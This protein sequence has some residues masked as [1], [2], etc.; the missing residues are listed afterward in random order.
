MLHSNQI[1]RLQSKGFTL[2]ELLV[3]I[4]IIGILVALLLPAINSARQAAYRNSCRN[5]LKQMSLGANSYADANTGKVPYSYRPPGATVRIANL[6]LL[7]PFIEENNSFKK[8]DL[9]QNWSAAVNLPVT[10][11]VIAT[12]VCP[13]QGEEI[14]RED[15]DPQG[16]LKGTKVACGDY[17]PLVAVE[18]RLFDAGEVDQWG[19]G[20]MCKVVTS[21]DKPPKLKEITDGVSKTIFYSESHGRPFVYQGNTKLTGSF[22]T[23]HVNGGGWSRPA[24]DFSLD[25]STF[26]GKSFPGKC[27]INCT[28]G[29]DVGS[30]FP[31]PVYNTDGSGETYAFHPGGAHV[32]MADGSVHFINDTISIREF[33]RLVT[34]SGGEVSPSVE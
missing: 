9:T 6:T 20:A 27:A 8:L 33:A 26:D 17:S 31:H 23:N 13:S 18:K 15:V 14:S 34:R 24:S 28:N 22:D 1:R 21:T 3:V 4:A 32:A 30:A 7:L 10:Q 25:G 29:E 12:Y 2:V 11:K 19:K 5:N 16:A